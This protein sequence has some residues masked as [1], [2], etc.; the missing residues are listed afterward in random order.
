MS[1]V[2]RQSR[3]A[4]GSDSRRMELA[5]P[6]FASLSRKQLRLTARPRV[7]AAT[8]WGQVLGTGSRFLRDAQGSSREGCASQR[9]GAAAGK[10]R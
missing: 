8:L 10:A 1:H 2:Q 7:L 5:C 9:N 6:R 3:L 4:A